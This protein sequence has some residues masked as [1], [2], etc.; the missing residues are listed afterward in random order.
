MG[1]FQATNATLVL[2]SLLSYLSAY[3]LLRRIL[4]TSAFGSI[5]GAFFFAF[6][7]PKFA[8]L[9]HLQLRFDF[10]QPL[11]LGVIAPL[12]LE[13][14]GDAPPRAYGE[15]G[16]LREPGC[17]AASTAFY[18]AWFFAFFLGLSAVVAVS[19]RR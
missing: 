16:H 13:H 18:N 2:L 8:Q 3:W 11:A 14:S 15:D 19:F 4:K 12:L 1:L 10:F 6:A 9:G 7:Y 17:L 5:V